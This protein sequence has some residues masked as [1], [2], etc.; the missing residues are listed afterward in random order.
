MFAGS[1]MAEIG[2]VAMMGRRWRVRSSRRWVVAAVLVVVAAAA[3]VPFLSSGRAV[4][5]TGSRLAAR[6]AAGYALSFNGVD[7]Y[8]KAADSSSLRLENTNAFSVAFWMYLRQVGNNVLPRF[9][10]KGGDFLCV[11]GDRSN[12]RFGTIG[13][14]VANAS[15]VGNT[16]GGVSEFW[17][18]TRLQL[19]RWYFVAVTFDGGRVS[20]QARIYLDGVPEKTTN[21]YPWSGRLGST[22]G[23]P[24]FIGRRAKDLSRPLDGR[25]DAMLVYQV[26]LSSSQ[27]LQLYRGQVPGGRAAD[28]EFDEGSGT[29]ARDSSGKGNDAAVVGAVYGVR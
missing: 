2:V 28:W 23:K 14:E 21:V 16:N 29:I 20:P 27:V 15:G 24:W 18:S 26:A 1:W 6:S 13:L 22:V 17:G 11:M 7:A 8:V 25:L 3:F 5:G 10:E 4:A 12:P 9:W 19:G